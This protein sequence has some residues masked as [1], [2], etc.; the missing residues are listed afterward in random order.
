M[1]TRTLLLVT[2]ALCG[3]GATACAQSGVDIG[4]KPPPLSVAEWVKGDPV[5]LKRDA[6]KKVHVIEFWATWCPPCKMSVPLLTEYQKKYGKDL[7]IVGVTE[8]DA[9]GN[10]PDAIRSFVAEQGENM[11]YVVA[12]DTGDTTKAY[13]SSAGVVGLPHAF[14]VN[15]DGQVVWQGN[16]LDPN[17]DGVLAGVIDGSY[18]LKAARLEQEVNKRLGELDLL[19]QLGQWGIVWEQLEEILKIDPSNEAA[20]HALIITSEELENADVLRGWLRS[21]IASH[22][23]N[24]L[25]MQRLAN[26]LGGICEIRRRFPDLAFEAA[27][28]AYDASRE[29]DA[30]TITVYARALYQVGDLD[31][32]IAMQQDAVAIASGASLEEFKGYLD[33]YRQCK[34]VREALP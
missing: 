30:W 27:K 34:K 7:V 1:N 20:L 13:L 26:A 22:R 28:A 24:A 29:P 2:A 21:H 16:P 15:R 33:Y 10:S 9:R 6:R 3:Y 8:P 32:A 5:D 17:L 11:D 19:V 4:S 12:I 25:A 23:D 14:V 18:D 31:R